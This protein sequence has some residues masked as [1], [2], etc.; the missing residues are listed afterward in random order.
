MFSIYTVHIVINN[1]PKIQLKKKLF[2]DTFHVNKPKFDMND[3]AAKAM[4]L[5][6]NKYLVK[7]KLCSSHILNGYIQKNVFK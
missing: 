5:R 2:I 4:F 3:V 6:P 7:V 1:P